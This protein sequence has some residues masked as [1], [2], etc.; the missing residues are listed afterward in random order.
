MEPAGN[1]QLD[2]LRRRAEAG[3]AE[4]Q[5]LLGCAYHQSDNV[6]RDYGQPPPH[7]QARAL[8]SVARAGSA[9]RKRL[10]RR[11]HAVGRVES[12]YDH[13]T[14]TLPCL[15][16][17][18][19]ALSS[20]SSLPFEA[21]HHDATVR[22]P[23]S[24]PETHRLRR[25][26]PC[27]SAAVRR[28]SGRNYFEKRVLGLQRGR[29]LSAAHRRYCEAAARRALRAPSCLPIPIDSHLRGYAVQFNPVYPLSGR[30]RLCHYASCGGAGQRIK[31]SALSYAVKRRP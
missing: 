17:W 31:R 27:V 15:R 3:D 1:Q 19:L 5:F 12:I 20:N 4:A 6:A 7:H 28:R 10:M 23:S 24:A 13:R 30:G 29:V 18:T 22:V 16:P 26:Y 14:P 21:S 9:D 11:H 2:E 8:P 25:S